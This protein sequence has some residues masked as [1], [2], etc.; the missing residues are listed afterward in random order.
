MKGGAW[1]DLTPVQL[2]DGALLG[3]VQ[4]TCLC[5]AK[6]ACYDLRGTLLK[7]VRPPGRPK[8]TR[9]P[10]RFV[11]WQN[12]LLAALIALA[13][14]DLWILPPVHPASN[15]SPSLVWQFLCTVMLTSTA[16]SC[17]SSGGST[18]SMPVRDADPGAAGARF[19]FWWASAAWSSTA[20]WFG[21]ALSAARRVR[22]EPR[23]SGIPLPV[24]LPDRQ[25]AL[26]RA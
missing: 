17:R 25:R 14:A 19:A 6:R 12:R 5:A 10:R 9:R 20:L 2:R 8:S 1:R 21:G 15:N 18:G 24:L 13:A 4:Q 7:N 22:T 11:H 26:F 16:A 23:W 3:F